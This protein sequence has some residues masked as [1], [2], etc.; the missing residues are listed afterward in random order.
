MTWV[1]VDLWPMLS[2]IQRTELQNIIISKLQGE[3]VITDKEIAKT[4]VPCTIRT[5]RNAR[6]N[7]LQYGTIDA[8]RMT[9]G[10]P[11]EVTENLWL[12]LQNQ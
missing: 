6:S 4:I 2:K 8:P 11:R 9:T 10:R 7:I 12:A 5:I 1:N 3:E